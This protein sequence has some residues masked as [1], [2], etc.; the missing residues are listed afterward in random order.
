MIPS[1]DETE[2]IGC[3][4]QVG[5]VAEHEELIK[6]MRLLHDEACACFSVAANATKCVLS[7][8]QNLYR[9]LQLQ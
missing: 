2:L 7:H 9:K 3:F 5:G 4:E 6:N 1:I 8:I